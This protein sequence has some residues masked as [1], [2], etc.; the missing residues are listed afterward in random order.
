MSD[1]SKWCV[2]MI[3]VLSGFTVSGQISHEDYADSLKTIQLKAIQ[4]A[5]YK[6]SSPGIE[7][8]PAVH[9]NFIVSGKKNDVIVLGSQPANLAEKSARQVFGKIPG[10]FVYDMDGSGNQVNIATRGLDPHRSWEFN[11][12]QNGVMTNSDI[13][14]YPASHYSP[15]M[16]AMERIELIRGTASLQYGAAFGGMVNYVMKAPDTSS[17][18]NYET[19]NSV[20]SFQTLSSFHAISGTIKRLSYYAYTQFRQADTYRDAG[21]SEAQSQHIGLI[22][23]M[24]TRLKLKAEMSR[25][26][27]V[28]QMPG[29]LT[30]SLFRDN[31]RQATRTRNFYEPDI[32]IPA[33]HLDW[34]VGPKTSLSWVNSWLFGVRNSVMFMAFA[35]VPD[36]FNTQTG[37]YAP[38]QVDIDNF[39]SKTSELRV[40]HEYTLGKISNTL[41]A[42]IQYLHND[43]RRRQ[44]GV[45]STGIDY[46]LKIDATGFG[47]DLNYR[48]RNMAV[49]AE[50]LIAISPRF[51]VSPGIRYE[52][53][54]TRR[55]GFMRNF[56]PLNVPLTI[57]RNFA[58]LGVNGQW[59]INSSNNV[60]GGWSQAYR[61]VILAIT[62]PANN[63]E[64]I[65]PNLKDAFGHNAELG[66]RGQLARNRLR[67]DVTLF[68]ML[69]KNRIG[70]I[71]ETNDQGETYLF[72]SNIGDTRTL[73]L[74]TFVEY[75][76]LRTEKWD[77]AVFSATSFMQARYIKGKLHK[78]GENIDIEG[79]NLEA[80]PEWISRNGLQ[81]RY[82]RIYASLQ[83]SYVGSS[84]SD[85]FNS[86]TSSA[87][88]AVGPVPAYK[89]TDFN[90]SWHFRS[91]FT[92]QA[93]VNNLFDES[94]FTKRP[95][96]YPGAGI[97]SSDGRSFMITLSV[98][99]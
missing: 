13:Y 51:Q 88:G 39:D 87:T 66:I 93:S 76:F 72:K 57:D 97:W 85:A 7:Y 48:S 49:Y 18:F 54:N 16:E 71:L 10:V 56:D 55:S 80:V 61:P 82:K 96:G 21:R 35:N 34:K 84:Y 58:L 47:R 67:Y 69:Y 38:R 41:V 31:P 99:I 37:S 68:E 60:Y 14:G 6:P 23:Q 24:N 50:N 95:D 59:T 11:V 42:G 91:H 40:K 15:P 62:I 89:L 70:A 27:Y 1:W 12:R 30:D 81:I 8:L 65:D 52:S 20:G 83:H 44:Q 75:R 64:R 92:V 32:Y 19:I 63:L 77:M 78:A 53:G 86:I 90:F 45:G 3:M 46:D 73:G 17:Q 29:Q 94:Y 25:S 74:E 33:I 5:T 26:Q 22:W 36:A 9:K 43:M 2:C 79:N 4:I 98:R 28:F